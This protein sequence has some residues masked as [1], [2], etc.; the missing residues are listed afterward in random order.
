MN[1]SEQSRS[2]TAPDFQTAFWTT[3]RAM[4]DAGERIFGAHGVRSGQQFVLR[5]LWDEDGLSPGEVARRLNLATPTV[6]RTA[7]RLAAAGLLQRERHDTDA[8]LVRLRLTVEGRRL[9]SVIAQEMKRLT[10][11]A[12][13]GFSPKER[14]LL[15]ALLQRIHQNLAPTRNGQSE[16]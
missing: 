9:E 1:N 16:R 2:S 10:E 7:D 5:C 11:E 13:A 4:F 12:L 15:I 8:R 6:T 14:F 3:K